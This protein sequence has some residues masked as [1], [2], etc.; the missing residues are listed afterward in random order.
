MVYMNV[1]VNSGESFLPA[2]S[3]WSPDGQGPWMTTSSQLIDNGLLDSLY[4]FCGSPLLRADPKIFCRIKREV[5]CQR[6]A[7]RRQI[8][9][10]PSWVD[11]PQSQQHSNQRRASCF[12]SLDRSNRSSSPNK[13]FPLLYQPKTNYIA[14]RVVQLPTRPGDSAD[15][16]TEPN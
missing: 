4:I 3:N 5:Y 1:R 16:V 8:E 6:N 13:L 7:E 11:H 2:S 12:K 9:P 10:I 14:A 15:Q